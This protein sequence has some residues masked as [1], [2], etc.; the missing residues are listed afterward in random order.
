MAHLELSRG[1]LDMAAKLTDGALEQF[2]DYHYALG[3]LAQVHAAQGRFD[4]ATELLR[5]RYRAAAHP[6]NLYDLGMM[7]KRAGRTREGQRLLLEF[8]GKAR[9]ESERWDN[10]NRELVFCQVDHTARPR[11][12]LGVAEREIARR[13]DVFTRDAHAWALY[14]NGRYR[15]AREQIEQALGVGIRNAGMFYRAG[16]IA[17]RQKD[18]AA[19]KR[20]LR[21]SLETN[22]TSEYAKAARRALENMR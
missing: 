21:L 1:H 16:T 10:A 7:L 8:E 9:A 19:A 22:P 17:A 5:K 14:A 12:A 11:D 15:E 2:P 3:V 20:Y 13:Q 18:R 6:E 4:A